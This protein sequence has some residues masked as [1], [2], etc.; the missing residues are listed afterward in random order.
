MTSAQKGVGDLE[1]CKEFLDSIID[2][3]TDFQNSMVLNNRYL[4]FIF[5][6]EGRKGC[7]FCRPYKC[8]TPND[9][10]DNERI[11]SKTKNKDYHVSEVKTFF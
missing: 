9:V 1:I 8:M 6:D 3:L 4:L 2:C 5:V 10:N 7:H 11:L